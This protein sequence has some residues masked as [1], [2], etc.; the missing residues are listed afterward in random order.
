MK[1][2]LI[3]I[4]A[5]AVTASFTSCKSSSSTPKTFCDTVCLKDSMKFTGTHKM[6]PYVYISAKNCKPDSILWSYEGMGAN[7]MTGFAY[8]LSSDINVNPK[9]F[10]CVFRD[11]AAAWL[12]FNDCA[13][14][15]GYQVKLPYDIKMSFSLKSSGIN[16]FDPKFSVADN[17]L[18]NTDRGNI[19]VE[20][21]ATGK[22]AMMT[23]GQ[24]LDIDY[25]ALHNSIDSV[26]ITDTRI[27][28]KLKVDNEWKEMEKKIVLE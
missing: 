21:M 15:R 18:V 17:L 6:H 28:V 3:L 12:L 7:R 13:T 25:D 2:L 22:N 26:N 19:Y 9:Y 14:G 23:F 5:A 20:D 4:I 16:N 10:R 11:T 24:K 27:W 8:L 1:A